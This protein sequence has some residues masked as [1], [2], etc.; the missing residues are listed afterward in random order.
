MPRGDFILAL[1]PKIQTRNELINKCPDQKGW[2]LPHRRRSEN[3]QIHHKAESII[4]QLR[5]SGNGK[6]APVLLTAACCG[7]GGPKCSRCRR[8]G[9]HGSECGRHGAAGRR[10]HTRNAARGARTITTIGRR[11]LDAAR[12]V[13]KGRAK[14]VAVVAVDRRTLAVHRQHVDTGLGR[15]TKDVRGAL[16][17]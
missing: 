10:G 15:Q 1:P 6:G 4:L 2:G 9:D 8:R 5:C 14:V 17:N 11:F 7:R 3:E 13:R 16:L 12:K